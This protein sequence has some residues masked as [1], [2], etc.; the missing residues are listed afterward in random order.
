MSLNIL[1]WGV[2]AELVKEK[3]IVDARNLLDP[4]RIEKIWVFLCNDWAPIKNGA[5]LRAPFF[6]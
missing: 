5:F 1:I 4:P 6:F 2:L 3:V